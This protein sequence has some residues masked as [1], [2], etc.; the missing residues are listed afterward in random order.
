MTSSGLQD[1]ARAVFAGDPP[2]PT[3]AGRLAAAATAALTTRL[4]LSVVVGF[5]AAM[6]LLLALVGAFIAAVAAALG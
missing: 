1:R 3:A 6:R 2:S 4:G 5:L